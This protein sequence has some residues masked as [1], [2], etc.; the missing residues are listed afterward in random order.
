VPHT[1]RLI[2]PLSADLTP[3]KGDEHSE[4]GVSYWWR[5]SC[6]V[7]WDIEADRATGFD[8]LA[9]GVWILADQAGPGAPA[10]D[11]I[12]AGTADAPAADWVIPGTPSVPTVV[13]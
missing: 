13:V 4:N 1:V 5:V 3:T 12:L 6:Q 7:E 9:Q 2:T 8:F 10:V 11:W